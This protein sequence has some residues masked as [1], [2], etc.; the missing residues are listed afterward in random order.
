MAAK[1]EKNDVANVVIKNAKLIFRNFSGRAGKFNDEGER[2]FNVLI[3]DRQLAEELDK[4][5]WN[6]KWPKD[7]DDDRPPRLPVAVAFDPY[8][9]RIKQVQEGG[10]SVWLDESNVFTLDDAEIIKATVV[11]RPYTWH[12]NDGTSGIKAYLRELKVK[13]ARDIFCDDEEDEW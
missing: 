9:P 8:P 11:I 10:G 12:R 2:S 7:E 3:E 4:E 6:I 5:G 13:I 1:K